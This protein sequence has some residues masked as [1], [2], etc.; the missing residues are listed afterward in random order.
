MVGKSFACISPYADDLEMERMLATQFA[1]SI[2]GISSSEWN[3]RFILSPALYCI[4]HGA[5]FTISPNGEIGKTG[6]LLFV[7]VMKEQNV[8]IKNLPTHL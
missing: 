2:N 3:T 5:R 4:D 6:E 1:S 8:V 7:E